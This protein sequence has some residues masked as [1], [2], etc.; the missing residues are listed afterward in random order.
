MRNAEKFK[1]IFGLYSTELWAKPEKK[2][3]QWANKEYVSPNKKLITC[4]KCFHKY[5]IE[6][7]PKY[8]PNYK[9]YY[10]TAVCPR[11]R[12]GNFISECY[13]TKEG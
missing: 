1:E 8:D 10:W 9:L 2:F 7:I 4:C 13:M 5:Y 11:C 3:L 12:Q 6:D